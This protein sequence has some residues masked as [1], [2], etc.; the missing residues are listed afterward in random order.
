MIKSFAIV[1][2][3]TSAVLAQ[4]SG[5]PTASSIIPSGIS[6]PCTDFLN[7]LNNDATLKTC[8][9]SLVGTTSAYT[10]GGNATASPSSPQILSTL[11]SLCSASTSSNC[12]D[13]V[14]RK[15]LSQFYQECSAEL[16]SKP[17]DRV[18]ELYD[19]M[20]ML[21]PLR[22]A[23][24]SKN[25]N[26]TYCVTQLPASNGLKGAISTSGS[27]VGENLVNSLVQKVSITR[28][29][30]TTVTLPNVTTFQTTNL[31]FL[32][33][34]PA[35]GDQA[36]LSSDD[37]CSTCTRNIMT[38]YINF[39]SDTPYGPGLGESTLLGSQN[40]LYQAITHTCGGTFLSGVVQAAGGLSG[41]GL[42]S[43][44]MQN[45]VTVSQSLVATGMGVL[46]VV[47][48]SVF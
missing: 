32:F 5:T 21:T 2:L 25:D 4:S 30:D 33:L 20:Y 38:A 42:S 12:P 34:K 46:A 14:M 31:P 45:V 36:A 6:Q 35:G 48:S 7:S 39:E 23:L 10:P 11:N 9:S 41:G 43:G 13:N 44:A 37:Q 47:V 3:F 26:G 27:S 16:T 28:R 18:K 8:T 15:W 19:I 24:C 22:T 29:A 1:S 40:K 17:V